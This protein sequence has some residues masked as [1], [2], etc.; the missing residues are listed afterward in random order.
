MTTNPTR[1]GPTTAVAPVERAAG[2]VGRRV[3]ARRGVLAATA[4]AVL[5]ELLPGAITPLP[6]LAGV[7]LLLGAPIAVWYG[8]AS[9][10]V[11][12]RDGRVLLA[13]GLSVLSSLVVALTVNSVLPL[14]GV[15]GPLT[16][17]AL[18]I[19]SALA[20]T[21]A[22]VTVDPAAK[23][24]DA[25]A[26]W[27]R[28]RTRGLPAGL[29][30]VTVLGTLALALSVAGP[31]RLNNQLGSGVS[32][33]AL[34]TIAALLAL[35][36]IRY[37]RY[38]SSVVGVGLFFA[39]AG[40]LLLSSL[41]GWHITGH[42]IQREYEV[43]GLTSDQSR[44]DM[45]TFADPYNACLSITLLPTSWVRL[46]DIPGPYIFKVV[47]P[48]LFAL[49][50]VL[51][52]RSVRNVAPP[53]VAVLSAVLFMVFPTFFTDMM[54][55]ARQEVAFVFLGCAMVVL[56]DK[57]RALLRRR[58]TF[59]LMAVGV[60]LAHYS[61]AYV[62]LAALALAL[63]A[64]L[65][66]RVLARTR[67]ARPVAGGE[68]AFVTWWIVVAAVGA[69]LVW[70]GPLTNTA[71]QLR[72]TLVTSVQEVTSGRQSTAW[73]SDVSYSLFGGSR[74]SPEERL[75]DFQTVTV[76]DTAVER[77]AGVYVPWSVASPGAVEPAPEP[78]L[79]LTSLGQTAEDRGVG[80]AA[81]GDFLR[82]A[83]ARLWQVFLL[84]GI[85]TSF[86][87]RRREFRPTRDQVTLTVGMI[88]V[89]GMLTVLPQLSVEYG[90]LRA[91]QQG[92]FVFAPFI[93][94]GL[95]WVCRWVGRRWTETLACSVVL[96]LFFDLTGLLPKLFGG[97]PPQL[98]L[99]NAGRYYDIYYSHA[100]ERAALAWLT[101][102]TPPEELGDVQS[103]NLSDRFNLSKAGTV[104]PTTARNDIHPLLIRED[105]TV[106]LGT[107]TTRNDEATIF[108]GGDL[109]TYKYPTALLEET[110]NKIYSSDGAEIYR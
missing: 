20:V 51:V 91:F 106:L 18:A 58:I 64:D 34:V 49:A 110:K 50:P 36:M 94:A 63:V 29:V 93:A 56:T 53:F 12:T 70:T 47:L 45:A 60:V 109:V 67:R 85:V 48:L 25:P 71:G 26:W 66:W 14:V 103:E 15:E 41:R 61:T 23:D 74:S 8:P 108:Y 86:W 22:A 11:S 89:I 4:L 57:G 52:H 21:A 107:T 42:D 30:A 69:A 54:F 83:A 75:R 99:D 9:R 55:L 39:A 38:S 92:L 28:I 100:E 101:A 19:G 90:L 33:A 62:F 2:R 3:A 68:P 98:H 87:A 105:A 77:A 72:S 80:V 37:R 31:I 35:L 104:V 102:R 79:P 96:L 24:P 81:V 46:T 7:W 13:A 76:R 84:L 95:V 73:S 97:N 6:T 16:R 44:W 32:I 27:L 43:F 59:V 88:A 5:I 1:G 78:R 17:T 40:L 82:Q 10:I 65:C